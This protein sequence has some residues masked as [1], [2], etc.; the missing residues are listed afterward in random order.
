MKPIM[1]LICLTWAVSSFSQ[2]DTSI[3]YT[4]Q[5]EAFSEERSIEI[6]LPDRYKNRP[7]DTFMVTYVLDGQ[8]APFF[9]AVKEGMNYMV[10]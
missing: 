2:N 3:I 7:L 6:Y 10:Q 9:D 5:S 8:Y 1:C 4:F